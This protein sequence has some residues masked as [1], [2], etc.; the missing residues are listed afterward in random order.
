M[1]SPKSAYI[2]PTKKGKLDTHIFVVWVDNESGVLAR[3]VGLFSG[4]GYNIERLAGAEIDP[5]K[6]DTTAENPKKLDQVELY[7][8]VTKKHNLNNKLN[9]TILGADANSNVTGKM[10][11]S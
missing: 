4:R 1:A 9:N 2:I 8:K 11:P 10:E 5:T 3:V 7:S 6:I